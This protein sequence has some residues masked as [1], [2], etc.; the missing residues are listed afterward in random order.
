MAEVPDARFFHHM[1]VGEAPS[2]EIPLNSKEDYKIYIDTINELTE[3]NIPV[4]RFNSG[5]VRLRQETMGDARRAE[6]GIHPENQPS[7]SLIVEEGDFPVFNGLMANV[8][9]FRRVLQV[10]HTNP[11][12]ESRIALAFA[13]DQLLAFRMGMEHQEGVNHTPAEPLPPTPPPAQPTK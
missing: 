12:E 4:P 11:T 13:H 7:G 10:N 9:N 6:V 8:N 5:K 2:K 1:E 3:M